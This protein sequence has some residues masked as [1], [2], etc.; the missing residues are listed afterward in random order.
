MRKIKILSLLLSSIMLCGCMSSCGEN[1]Q[2]NTL[3]PEIKAGEISSEYVAEDTD[4]KL[5]DNRASDYVIVYPVI[6]GV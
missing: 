5:V 2:G 4:Y 3:S 1:S 6:D